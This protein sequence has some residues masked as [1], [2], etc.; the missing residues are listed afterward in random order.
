MGSSSSKRSKSSSSVKSSSSAKSKKSARSKV[1]STTSEEESTDS[2]LNFSA[3]FKT[4]DN[5]THER[6]DSKKY[7]ISHVRFRKRSSGEVNVRRTSSER[8]PDSR[9]NAHTNPNN[10]TEQTERRA[11]K[12]GLNKSLSFDSS[13]AHTSRNKN[14]DILVSGDSNTAGVDSI[15]STSENNQRLDENSSVAAQRVNIEE[16]LLSNVQL[17]NLLNDGAL[18]P[19]ICD[20]TYI[21][22]IDT[23]SKK[24]YDTNHIL[25]ARHFTT[26]KEQ[27]ENLYGFSTKTNVSEFTWVV[28][29]GD[30]LSDDANDDNDEI[31]VMKDLDNCYDT[32]L[33]ILKTGFK[34]F[35]KLYPFLCSEHEK[36]DFKSIQTYPSIILDEQ[37]YQGRGDQATSIKVITDLEITHVINITTEHA[38][39]FPEK[40]Q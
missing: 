32:D 1:G 23:R 17:Y 2:N 12:G 8:K 11:S 7:W 28:I 25:L 24:D 38:S 29:Y 31:K 33:Y 10:L 21:L 13:T 37:L 5:F 40:I 16:R 30:G 39:A 19:C 3:R 22:L 36:V 27:A 6:K 15:S 4:N 26:I 20:P 18:S 35:E 9:F 14:T 34:S